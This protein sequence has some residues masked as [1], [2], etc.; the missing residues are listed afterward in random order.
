MNLTCHL[1]CEID[2]GPDVRSHGPGD[3]P[4][5]ESS[6]HHGHVEEMGSDHHDGESDDLLGHD[7]GHGHHRSARKLMEEFG[8]TIVRQY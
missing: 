7:H 1:D 5:E 2:R 6:H 8:P 3:H 4:C